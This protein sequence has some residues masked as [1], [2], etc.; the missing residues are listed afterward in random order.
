MSKV[1]IVCV[2]NATV[3]NVVAKGEQKSFELGLYEFSLSVI[4]ASYT[5][6]HSSI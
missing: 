6:L 1:N 2:K 4:L 5:V 3:L